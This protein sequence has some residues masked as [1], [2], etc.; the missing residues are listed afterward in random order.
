MRRIGLTHFFHEYKGTVIDNVLTHS[1][2]G[3]AKKNTLAV[4]GAHITARLDLISN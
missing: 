3:G 2:L 1:L 4:N